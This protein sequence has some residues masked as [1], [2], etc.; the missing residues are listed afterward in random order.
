MSLTRTS[1]HEIDF[2]HPFALKGYSEPFPPGHYEVETEEEQI[3]SVSFLAYRR[4]STLL[5][6]QGRDGEAIISRIFTVDPRDLDRAKLI[7]RSQCE[8]IEDVTSAVL[9]VDRIEDQQA[10]ARGENEGL[11]VD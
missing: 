7:D 8:P 2:I 9:K 5:Y 3:E 6:H 10:I 4:I 1:R 11:A